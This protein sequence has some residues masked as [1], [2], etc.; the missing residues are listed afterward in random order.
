VRRALSW[1]PHRTLTVVNLGCGS[2]DGLRTLAGFSAT[3]G[4]DLKLFGLD[5]N[6]HVID[7]ARRESSAFSGIKFV[8][9]DAFGAELE[10]LQPDIVIANQFFHHIPSAAI[11]AHLPK[12]LQKTHAIVI[13][14]LHRHVVA[15]TGFGLLARLLGASPLALHDG[16]VSIRRGFTRAELE[17]LTERLGLAHRSIVWAFPFRFEVVLVP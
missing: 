12:L 6:P 1:L 10:A 14:D 13:T 16:Q 7:I 17:R 8:V 2:G 9:G 5:A 4:I 15:H 3:H 11:E